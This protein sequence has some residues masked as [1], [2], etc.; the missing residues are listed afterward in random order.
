MQTVYDIKDGR[1]YY[2]VY[3]AYG[4]AVTV[5]CSIFD[6][7]EACYKANTWSKFRVNRIATVYSFTKNN[8]NPRQEYVADN[9]FVPEEEQKVG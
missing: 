5:E 3:K 8:P 9:Q 1:M 6:L 7:K 4:Q 2:V